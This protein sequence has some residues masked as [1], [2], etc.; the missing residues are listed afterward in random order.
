MAL[1]IC[2]NC[3]EEISVLSEFCPYCDTTIHEKVNSNVHLLYICPSCTHMDDVYEVNLGSCCIQRC[4]H[5]GH[6]PVNILMTRR[7]WDILPEEAKERVWKQKIN[8]MKSSSAFSRKMYKKYA[9]KLRYDKQV[10]IYCPTCG[11]YEGLQYTERTNCDYCGTKYK[12]TDIIY[13]D[14]IRI[15]RELYGDCGTEY[16]KQYLYD[17]FLSKE[18]S[19]NLDYYHARLRKEKLEHEEANRKFD[20]EMREIERSKQN[21]DNSSI[22]IFFD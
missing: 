4:F 22:G 18:T 5:C 7:D 17:F 8:E 11:R 12:H 16:E 3:G 19:F 14:I 13:D 1:D 6:M 10:L 15:T 21:N 9:D 20:E 2:P